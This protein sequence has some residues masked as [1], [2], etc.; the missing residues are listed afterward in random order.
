MIPK[1][2][3]KTIAI[4]I[5]SA[6]HKSNKPSTHT[7]KEQISKEIK[8]EKTKTAEKNAIFFTTSSST[9][10]A[11]RYGSELQHLPY[12]YRERNGSRTLI[13]HLQAKKKYTDNAGK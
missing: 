10:A 2:L 5:R 13:Q 1:P 4:E 8:S 6:L 7:K 11:M 12:L 3:M 9:A